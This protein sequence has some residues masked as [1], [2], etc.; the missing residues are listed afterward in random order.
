MHVIKLAEKVVTW[1]GTLAHA[2]NP[3][4]LGGRGRQITRSR[5]L[6]HLGQHGETLSLLKIQKLAERGWNAVARSW[7]TTASASWVQAIFLPL[8]P[9]SRW[10]HCLTPIIP[11]VWETKTGRSHETEFRFLLPRLECNGTI[12]AHHNLCLQGSSNSPASASQV[13][14]TTGAHHHAQLIFVFLV[15]TRFLHVDQDGLHLLT[16]YGNLRMSVVLHMKKNLYSVEVFETSLANMVKPH[17]Y[18]KIQKIN[19]MWWWAPVIPA[20]REAEA[21][22]SLEPGRQ[23]L[24]SLLLP[25]LEYNDAISVHHSLRLPVEIGFLR[26]GQADLELPTSVDPPSLTSESAGIIGV[27]HRTRPILTFHWLHIHLCMALK[28]SDFAVLKQ[29]LPLLEKVSNTYPDP[30]I[31]ELAVDLRITISTHGAFATEAVS[32]AAQST[33]NKKDPKGKIEEPQQSSHERHTDV[34]HSHPEQ[35]Q[36]HGIAPQT[37]LQSDAPITPQG[38]N[39]PSTTISQKSGSITTEQLQEVVLSAYDPQIPTRA[40]ALRTLSRWIEQREA[41]ALEM[42][43]KLLKVSRTHCEDTWAQGLALSPSLECSG[44]ILAHCNFH[45]L[46][47]S[48]SSASASQMESCSVTQAGVQW[49]DLSSLQ[50]SPPKFKQ[51]YCLSLPNRVSLSPRL[52]CSGMNLAH[53]NLCLLGSSDSPAS[54]FQTGFP[55]VG[56]AGLELLTSSD[57]PT[58]ASQSAEITGFRNSEYAR[59]PLSYALFYLRWSLALYQ[60][61]VQKCDLG[62]LQ[63]PP[64]RF[65]RFSCLSLPSSWDYRRTYHHAQLIFVFLIEMGFHHVCQDGFNLLTCLTMSPRLERAVQSQLTAT[66]ASWV[67][68]ILSSQPPEY[69]HQ[70]PCP[71]ELLTL[72]KDGALTMLPRLKLL[73]SSNPLTSASQRAGI[74]GKS[75]CAQPNSFFIQQTYITFTLVVQAGVQWHDLG[76]L[77]PPPLGSNK[78]SLLLTRLECNSA[79]SAHPN[80]CLLVQ[81]NLLLQ[82]PEQL[83]LQKWDFSMLV[84]L[85]SN[86]SPQVICPPQPLKVL[87]LQAL[88]CSSAVSAHCILYLPDLSS[89]PASASQVTG[90]TGSHFYAQ[91]VF[92]E[93]FSFL[94]KELSGGKAKARK[95]EDEVLLLLPR[96]HCSDTISAHCN[97][98]LPETGF[99]HVGQTCVELLTSGDPP[100][101]ASQSAGIT[102]VSHCACLTLSPRLEYNGVITT[103]CNLSFPDVVSLLSPRLEYSGMIWAHC[104]L[105]LPGSSDSHGSAS[106]VVGITGIKL[107]KKGRRLAVVAHACNPSTLGSQGGWITSGQEFKT[108]LTNMTESQS[109][110][111]A[112]V[113]W[114]DLGSLQPPPPGFS[115]LS[116]LSSRNY[117]PRQQDHLRSGDQ[118]QPG[119]NDET[120]SLLKITKI[121]QITKSGVQDQPGQ[122]DETLCLLKIQK[123]ASHGGRHLE[124]QLLGRLRQENRLKPEDGG[125]SEL[126]R[127]CHCTP[128]W[129]KECPGRAQWLTPVI[130]ALWETEIGEDYL[131]PGVQDQPSEHSKLHKEN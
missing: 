130:P 37:G 98:H 20:T 61:G 101:L 58:S 123:L 26:V 24:I 33:L 75:H 51:F 122:H 107:V 109:V 46:G 39:E 82:P 5:D 117:R 128:A 100:S 54:A 28:S 131:R 127:S 56:Q 110:A 19:Q 68:A 9:D 49:R 18:Q 103:H 8:P 96:L 14:G 74:T 31:Q 79:I 12:S 17:L 64:P 22:E 55:H 106:G 92:L 40:V 59:K 111:Q 48:N 105:H 69:R 45:L 89:S 126:L 70:P 50:P 60:A 72:N 11:S 113:Q 21:G 42:Q 116:F 124:S 84:R 52:E 43:E 71:A 53:H 81:V 3:S 83:G 73:D 91:L 118:D 78:V 108:S 27:S 87:G 4:T 7:L 62:S 77:Q 2:C 102:G 47:S 121:S 32:M 90:T 104:N 112:G 65:K 16:S 57:P 38:V 1:L 66:S 25:K 30:V 80:L 44:M 129:A 35:Q 125:C 119:Q 88:E 94:A 95:G 15:E 115:C 85:V 120:L 97:L 13:A 34:A 99:Y 67:Q 10:A 93:E 76:S 41:K 36:S 6:D 114:C 63:P 29:L 86:S 23:R